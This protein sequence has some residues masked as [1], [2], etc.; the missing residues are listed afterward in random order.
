MVKDIQDS[1][2]MFELKMQQK[3]LHGKKQATSPS[4]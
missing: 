1:I 3:L 2:K 4:Q